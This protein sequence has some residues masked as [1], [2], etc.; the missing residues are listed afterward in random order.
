[1]TEFTLYQTDSPLPEETKAVRA[2][3]QAYNFKHL[4]EYEFEDLFLAFKDPD[5]IIIAGL[6]GVFVLEA[7]H[8]DRL[9][10]DEKYRGQKLATRLMQQSTQTALAKNCDFIFLDTFSFQALDFYRKLNFEVIGE[11]SGY[12]RGFS[13]YFL[14]KDLK[15]NS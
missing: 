10:T 6:T 4:S 15:L 14:Q 9:W 3:L 8:I 11:A 7:L 1:M 5:G 12:P 13:R 2:G